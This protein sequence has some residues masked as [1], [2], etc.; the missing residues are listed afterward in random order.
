[1][2]R[3]EIIKAM[4]DA[5]RNLGVERLSNA[6]FRRQSG[7]SE[8]AVLK[9]FDSWSD[10]CAA[11][12]INCG[13]TIENLIPTPRL[14]EEACIAE[15]QRV[16]NVLGC[17]ALSSKDFNRHARF[18]SKPVIDRFGSWQNAIEHAGLELCEQSKREIPLS[19][20]EC[21]KE[22]RRVANLLGMTSLSRDAFDTRTRFSAYRISRACGGWVAALK[23]AGLNL[24]P[25]YK[26]E[27]PLEHL[28]TV[29]MQVVTEVNRI[30]TL[31]QLVRRSKHAADS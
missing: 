17:K 16:A 6:A 3:D 25:Q 27:L 12:G 18:T 2:H 9:H 30:P 26:H 7:I 14:S 1:M 15:L 21:V 13:Q 24:S 28:A 19:E 5:A 22:L 10:A 11:A 4:Q 20:D 23:K 31:V 8:A 29:F